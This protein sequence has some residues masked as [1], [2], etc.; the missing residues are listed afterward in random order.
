MRP[1]YA[2]PLA[3]IV[4]SAALGF[5]WVAGST[6]VVPVSFPW[7]LN[8]VQNLSNSE[9][10]SDKAS[11][12]VVSNTIHVVWVDMI[13][14]RPEIC[15]TYKVGDA[16]W[17]SPRCL[18][19]GTDPDLSVGP[20]GTLDLVW[21]DD[22][23]IGAAGK[24]SFVRYRR[25]D[26]RLQMWIDGANVTVGSR[27][28]LRSPAVAVGPDGVSHV[29]WVDS[30][31]DSPR[32]R[33][34]QRT[35]SG[36][37]AA[38]N[39]AAGITPDVATDSSG[40]LHVVWSDSSLLG[41]TND[42]YYRRWHPPDN[43]SFTYV[44]SDWPSADSIDP[45]ISIDQE[46]WAHVAWQEIVDDQS[47]I[48]YRSGRESNWPTVSERVSPLMERAGA[49]AM[50]VDGRGVKFIAV[51]ELAGVQ[52]YTRQPDS[53]TWYVVESVAPGQPFT[54]GPDLDAIDEDVLHV[55]WTARGA[56]NETDVFYQMMGPEVEKTPTSTVAP[57]RTATA[58]FRVTL[59]STSTSTAV[60]ST[61]AP[62]ATAT[63]TPATPLTP[64]PTWTLEATQ[65]TRPSPTATPTL[66]P[67]PTAPSWGDVYLPM[68]LGSSAPSIRGRPWKSRMAQ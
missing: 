2:F 30:V 5:G 27:G 7:D 48:V 52:L 32:I 56:G 47:A 26:E 45:E 66:S 4:A 20:D 53:Q 34:R 49:P 41:E 51:E 59:T 12:A 18:E 65:T 15:H 16:D 8:E 11:I 62:T 19:A 29:V 36:W 46:G 38:E 54:S 14:L 28:T 23:Q 31:S 25:W 9:W 37:E 63:S 43:W 10:P 50:A 64:T 60:S 17:R 1:S 42:V 68:I 40:G 39:V 67:T 21:L 55:V 24:A 6:T 13:Y 33:Y 3:I 58:T 35:Q 22:Q 44:L 57:A 61:P